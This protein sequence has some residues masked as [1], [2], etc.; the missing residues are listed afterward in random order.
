MNIVAVNKL[1]KM[2]VVIVVANPS[3][4][5]IRK[6]EFVKLKKCQRLKGE[7]KKLWRVKALVVILELKNVNLILCGSK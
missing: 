2:V 4:C 3:N 6:M 1:Q 7:M 5:N